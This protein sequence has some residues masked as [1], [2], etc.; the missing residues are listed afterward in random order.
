MKLFEERGE[1]ML[2][3][4]HSTEI[5]EPLELL[6]R[7]ES[8]CQTIDVLRP[9]IETSLGETKIKR[10]G[11]NLISILDGIDSVRNQLIALTDGRPAELDLGSGYFLECDAKGAWKEKA[12]LGSPTFFAAMSMAELKLIRDWL[13]P[14]AIQTVFKWIDAAI[15]YHEVEKP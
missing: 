7:I 11:I 5:I 14:S 12:F 2:P 4:N 6:D 8:I 15:K 10:C 13:N 1:T 3:V 9:S